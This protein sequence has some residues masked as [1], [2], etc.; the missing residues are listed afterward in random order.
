MQ[1]VDSALAVNEPV[2]RIARQ[3]DEPLDGLLL[4]LWQVVMYAVVIQQVVLLDDVLP[5]LVGAPVAQVETR[6]HAPCGKHT[7][8]KNKEIFHAIMYVYCVCLN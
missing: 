4:L 8:G 6:L 3:L 5:R 1:F 2:G 7:N